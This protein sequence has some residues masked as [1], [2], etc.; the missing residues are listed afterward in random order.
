MNISKVINYIHCCCCCYWMRCKREEREKLIFVFELNIYSPH[1]ILRQS[2]AELMV[3]QFQF[4]LKVELSETITE[5]NLEF[6]FYWEQPWPSIVWTKRKER[7][8]RKQCRAIFQQ[9]KQINCSCGYIP[10]QSLNLS[11][12]LHGISPFSRVRSFV[13]FSWAVQF[14]FAVRTMI[15]KECAWM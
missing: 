15:V 11:K 8:Y 7:N 3:E 9:T 13:G 6:R 10:Y 4:F 14:A 1:L 2:R 12:Q 5:I